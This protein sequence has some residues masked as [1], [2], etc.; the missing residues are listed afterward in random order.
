[1]KDLI[2][3]S[4]GDAMSWSN[5]EDAEIVKSPNCQNTLNRPLAETSIQATASF[6]PFGIPG[7][8]YSRA[9]LG[10]PFIL[11][12][13]FLWFLGYGIWPFENIQLSRP[14]LVGYGDASSVSF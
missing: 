14:E 2:E 7:P 8:R 9:D 5:I 13:I 4:V 10:T 1:M 12:R 6:D 11:H 3:A